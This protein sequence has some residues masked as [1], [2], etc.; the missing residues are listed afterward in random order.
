MK[1]A[2]GLVLAGLC[3]LPT[4]ASAQ[5]TQGN[6]GK[7]WVKSVLFVQKTDERYD[8]NGV[9]RRY[10]TNGESDAK[11]VYTE[12]IV[13][14]QPNLDLWLQ[15][16]YFDLTF[17][18]DVQ[19]L[20]KTGFGDVRV[21]L[22]WNVAKLSGGQTPISI[23]AG[24]KAPLG[25]SPID[26]QLIP[27]GE[28]QW[29]LEGFAEVG[30]SFWP[31]PVYAILWLGYRIRSENADQFVDPGNEFVFLGEAGVNPTPGTFL[32]TTLDGF[33]GEART[34]DGVVTRSK[35]R[36]TTL[37]FTGAVQTG[38][39]WPEFGVRVPLSGQDFPAGIQFVIGIS[40]QIR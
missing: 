21:W 9:R 34:V 19:T 39:V 28:G 16:P 2:T 37:Q 12:I 13:G 17:R 6:P 33:R 36:I 29:D 35:R 8:A 14:L 5:W 1:L 31:A 27:L 7:I 3:F 23:R 25:E 18:D 30:H 40:S 10:F 11:A 4:T 32:K 20:S 15:V 22:R 24:A 26:A 38:P